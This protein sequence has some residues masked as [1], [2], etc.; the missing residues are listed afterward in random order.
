[1]QLATYVPQLRK[2]HRWMHEPGAEFERTR[3]ERTKMVPVAGMRRMH[4]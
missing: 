3:C 2:G 4:L 1:M